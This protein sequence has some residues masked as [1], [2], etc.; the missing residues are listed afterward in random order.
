MGI[1]KWKDVFSLRIRKYLAIFVTAILILAPTSVLSAFR[2]VPPDSSYS[3]AVERL[4]A[5]GIMRGNADG[6]F[7]SE[8]LVTR[9]Q[10]S[11]MIVV[12]AGMEDSANTMHGATIFSDID[13]MGWSTGYINA[14]LDKGYITGMA[15][16][17]F[18]PEDSLTFAQAC[19]ILVKALGYTDQD[20][21]GLW[22]RN[23]ME[24]AKTL[25]ITAGIDLASNDP[26]PRWAA[27]V[28]MDRLL[29]TNIK[30]TGTAAAKTF[31]D[32][33]NLFTECIVLGNSFTSDKIADNQVLT[34]KGT[35][36]YKSSE[37]PLILGNK[38]KLIIK[39]D[40]ITKAYSTVR[41]VMNITVKSAVETTL[42]YRD[43]TGT[44]TL[45]LPEKTEYYYQGVKQKYADLKNL[46]KSNASIVLTYNI[47]KTGFDYGVVCDP[48]Y[49]KPAIIENLLMAGN[50]ILPWEAAPENPILRSTL[51]KNNAPP[52]NKVGEAIELN[53]IKENDIVYKVSD[54]WGANTYY[55][56]VDNKIEGE[57]TGILPN[58]ISPAKI[59]IDGKD[60][61]LGK[62]FAMNKISSVPG[63]FTIG[64]HATLLI[65]YD[66]KVT[67]IIS[68]AG[69]SVSKY[70]FVLNYS[71][72]RSKRMED[73]NKI[74]YSVKMLLTDGTVETYKTGDMYPGSSKGKLVR[75]AKT[76]EDQVVLE[77]LSYVANQEY[78]I[79]KLE[80]KIDANSIAD[81]IKI[82]NLV[83]DYVGGDTQVKLI[84]WDNMP[85][86]VLSAG[87]VLYINADGPFYDI[88]ILVLDDVFQEK[89]KLGIVEKSDAKAANK[90]DINFTNT[91]KIGNSSR[92]ITT[93]AYVEPGTVLF[94]YIDGNRVTSY[95]TV[96][97][98]V[99]AEKVDAVDVKR[100]RVNG[101]T[102]Y[103]NNSLTLYFKDSSG[104]LAIKGIID[105]EPGKAYSKV[106]LYTDN[107]GKV[108][109]VVIT[110]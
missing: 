89:R 98:A 92:S 62:N 31:A 32:S 80:N 63:A 15:D 23:Y 25:G 103:F 42:T 87:K 52:I 54:I 36:Y 58:K 110:E 20:V 48:V 5:L 39:N 33:N 61:E 75:F 4:A 64:D 93:D 10:F 99:E 70:G 97:P 8:A 28:M 109:A 51:R 45:V 65:G 72:T 88:F 78:T 21:S 68:T 35:Y 43:E 95:G 53:Q 22:P 38:Y 67:D 37:L 101:N 41:A 11:K 100:I 66:D 19:T 17:K 105:I 13:P 14:A 2:D 79:D 26:L 94:V 69:N 71:E 29:M 107:Y 9:E 85:H 96:L 50:R 55:L 91:V 76:A 46:I 49:S 90:N 7:D 56:V 3:Q 34:D 57:I 12:A 108:E 59:Q 74:T 18:H 27:A 47:D 81:N 83:S 73:F 44:K 106:A 30:T 84:D 16:G 102:Y 77:P 82:F 60:Y 40:T 1:Y 6:S 24:K 104:T 86:G